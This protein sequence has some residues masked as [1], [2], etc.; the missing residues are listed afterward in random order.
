MAVVGD[1]TA[2]KVKFRGPKLRVLL[3]A[4]AELTKL[5]NKVREERQ[6]KSMFLVLQTVYLLNFK[7]VRKD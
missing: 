3:Q 1:V 7:S 2:S 6:R 5:Q 4:W